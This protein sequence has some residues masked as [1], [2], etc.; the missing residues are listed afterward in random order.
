MKKIITFCSF[1]TL[2]ILTQTVSALSFGDIKVYSGFA[3]PFKAEI[4]I[5][6]ITPQE[7][8]NTSIN[9]ASI[10]EFS[11]RGIARPDVLESFEFNFFHKKDK[12]VSLLVESRKPVKELSVDLLIEISGPKSSMI[13]AYSVLL[14]PEAISQSGKSSIIAKAL[15]GE[16]S[17]SLIDAFISLTTEQATNNKLAILPIRTIVSNFSNEWH[18]LL[19][20]PISINE[21]PVL[22]ANVGDST[23]QKEEL[24]SKR[25]ELD[26][27][28]QMASELDSQNELLREQVSHLEEE[29]LLSTQD[30]F[31]EAEPEAP[32]IE[33]VISTEISEGG[34]FLDAFSLADFANQ[35][36]QKELLI[37]ALVGLIVLLVLVKKKEAIT[38]RLQARRNRKADAEAEF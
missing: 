19:N 1:T 7:L 17:I 37:A 16:N 36:Q 8:K 5:P 21:T 15:I 34:S 28:R 10:D 26:S 30:I 11:K 33:D 22:Q 29:L 20:N 3:E 6:S 25:L 13:R 23:M 12:S 27:M 35:Q 31:T 24:V 32:Q 14:T 9:V 18:A 4:A 38:R 2:L